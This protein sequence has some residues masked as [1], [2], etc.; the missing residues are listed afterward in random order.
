M[1]E[2]TFMEATREALTTAMEQDPNGSVTP[3]SVSAALS[4]LPPAPP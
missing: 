3:L 2:I 4:V 1:R